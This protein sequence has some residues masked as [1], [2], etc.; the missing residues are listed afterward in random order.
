[1]NAMI[2]IYAELVKAGRR[3]LT[4][5]PEHLRDAVQTEMEKS[6]EDASS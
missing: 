6:H 3:K 2:P 4:D 5:V 1:M